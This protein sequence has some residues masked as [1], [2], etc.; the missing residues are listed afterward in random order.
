MTLEEMKARLAEIQDRL[1]AIHEEAG[2]AALAE[3]RQTEW[4][5]LD[6]ELEGLRSQIAAAEKRMTRLA[7]LGDKPGNV[8]RQAPAF[9]KTQTDDELYDLGELRALSY[10]GDD[11]L[12]RVSDNAKRAIERARFGVK[13]KE[14]A[15]ERAEELLETADNSSRDLA[16]RYLMT[17]SAEYE[18]AFTKTLRHGSDAFCTAEERQALVRAAQALGTDANGGYAVPFQLDPTVMLTSAGVVNPIREL[19]RVETIVGKEWQGV[20]SAGTSV[21]RAAEADESGESNFTL[22]QPV[23]RTNR[24]Q[25]FTV[26]SLEIDLSWS[27]L[28]SE[29]TRMLVDA[30]AQEENSFIT[31]TGNGTTDLAPQGINGG[32][33]AGQ[34][35]LTS[36][37]ADAFSGT[38]AIT[39]LY[40]LEEALDARWEGSASFLAHKSVYHTLRQVD[41]AGGANLWARIGEGNPTRLLDYP[42]Y[43][44]TALPSV[45]GAAGGSANA[46][47]STLMIFGDFR[48]FLIVD[49]IGMTV[50]L[51]P[52]VLGANRRPTGQR[53]VY[54]VWMNNSKILI[55]DAFRRLSMKQA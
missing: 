12:E 36:G 15:Q 35:V 34:N 39:D 19:A 45:T 33:A 50:E 1:R 42:T 43:R 30:K 22:A 48:Q 16:K 28:R 24:V 20:T 6:G 53:G 18:R 38:Q 10:S 37:A 29:I 23:V 54:A 31:G 4:D 40:R 17:G 21:S 41:E 9:K 55:P 8:E 51:V 2:E 47:N 32:L 25:G 26:F 49:R 14:A 44:S 3:E 52:H 27:A 11:F 46:A 7:E 13:E 5:E